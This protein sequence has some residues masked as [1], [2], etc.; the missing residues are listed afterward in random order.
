MAWTAANLATVEAEILRLTI[1]TEWR[2]RR[3]QG[4]TLSELRALRDEM[5]KEIAQTDG[6]AV[7]SYRAGFTRTTG[8]ST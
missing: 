6:T 3:R 1:S 7:K 5:L 4:Q 2:D 8:E